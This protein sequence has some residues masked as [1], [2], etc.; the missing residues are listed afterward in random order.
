MSGTFTPA[1]GAAP[2]LRQVRSQASMESRLMLRNGEQ[3]LLTMII[4]VLL[5]YLIFSRQ[6][7]RGIT[8]GAVK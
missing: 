7:I 8:S 3:L 6:L 5:L 1:P 4:P 2:F